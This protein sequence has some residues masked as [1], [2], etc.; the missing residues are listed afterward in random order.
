M[1]ASAMNPAC[2]TGA[3]QRDAQGKGIYRVRLPHGDKVS[4]KRKRIRVTLLGQE[5]RTVNT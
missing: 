5:E 2:V 1:Q 4:P 3:T